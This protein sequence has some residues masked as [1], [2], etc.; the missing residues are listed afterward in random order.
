MNG[1][2]NVVGVAAK[3]R[4]SSFWKHERIEAPQEKITTLTADVAEALDL[5][6]SVNTDTNVDIYKCAIDCLQR[7]FQKL[8]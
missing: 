1:C 8:E 3:L 2:R 4:G 7:M 6:H 5:L